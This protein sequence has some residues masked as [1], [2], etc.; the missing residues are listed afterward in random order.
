MSNFIKK[1]RISITTVLILAIITVVI[2]LSRRNSTMEE[3]ARNFAV[4]DTA[5]VTRLFLAKKD[6]SQVLLTKNNNSQWTINNEEKASNAAVE[7]LLETLK[8]M[9][10]KR[11]VAKSE[12]NTVV[13]HLSSIGVKVEVYQKKPLFTLLGVDFFNK[14]RLTRTFYVGDATQNNRGTYMVIEGAEIPYVV[15]IPGFRGYL[16]PRF[17]AKP[18]DW[19]DHTIISKGINQIKSVEVIHKENPEESF[20]I[21]KTGKNTFNIRRLQDNSLM[22]PFDTLKVLD[23]LASFNTVKFEDLLNDFEKKDSIINSTPFHIIRLK[24][25]QDKTNVI[26]TYQRRAPEGLNNVY[27]EEMKYDP[28]RMYALF[29]NEEDF[30]LVQ[31]YIFDNLTR[32]LS[33]FLP[34]MNM[35]TSQNQPVNNGKVSIKNTKTR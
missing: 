17:K 25:A 4:R 7:I 34:P 10:V 6:S 23:F 1:N 15:Y 5:S 19:R 11:P 28:D 26:K 31:F 22:I 12:H 35:S 30:A 20:R 8:K 21:N 13:K 14:E 9:D 29:N 2:L 27:G 33:Y 32:K 16:T 24:D 18:D 3:K